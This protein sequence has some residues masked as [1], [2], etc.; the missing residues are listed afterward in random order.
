MFKEILTPCP[1]TALLKT[2]GLLNYFTDLQTLKRNLGFL[3]A[4][5]CLLGHDL[6]QQGNEVFKKI[7]LKSIRFRCMSVSQYFD[8]S[9]NDPR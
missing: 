3:W 5:V 1:E 8:T 4:P 6:Q 7:L 2:K 9:R